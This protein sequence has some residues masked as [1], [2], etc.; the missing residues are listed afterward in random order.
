[1]YV[2]FCGMALLFV[3]LLV[4]SAFAQLGPGSLEIIRPEQ[5]G[6]IRLNAPTQTNSLLLLESSP[7]L[8]DWSWFATLH[9]A[10]FGYP[11]ARS[12]DFAQRFYRGS[13]RVRICLLYTSDAADE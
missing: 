6:W 12:P 4:H 2:R 5:N 1:M 10:A 11:D 9:D 8:R 3:L 7:N 13:R